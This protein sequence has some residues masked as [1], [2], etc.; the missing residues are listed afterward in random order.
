MNLGE[1]VNLYIKEGYEQADAIAKV[2][3][4]IILLKISKSSL[5]KNV[6]IKDI[7]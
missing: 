4:D 6:T 3:Q 2:S 1:L 7:W 5:N